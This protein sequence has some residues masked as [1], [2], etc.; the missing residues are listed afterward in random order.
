MKFC[1]IIPHY[2]HERLFELFL[3]KILDLGLP[4]IIVDDGSPQASVA[5]LETL[6]SKYDTFTLI[7]H[8]RNRGKGAAVITACQH[9]SAMGFDNVIQIDADGQHCIDDVEKM[10]TYAQAN[11]NTIISGRPYF[12]ESAPKARVY[13]RKVT[14]FWVAIETLSLRVKDS[15]CGFR[16]YP[17]NEIET[18]FDN[19]HF[20]PRMDFD[21]EIL[22]KAVWANMDLHFIPTKVIYHEDTVS[23]FDYLRD[24]MMLINLHIRLVAGMLK[25]SPV[26]LFRR[27]RGLFGR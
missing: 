10:M 25:R 23:H 20:G 3:P 18:L 14:D 11:P 2:K 15:L 5:T 24:N 21:T 9:A 26:L 13:G 22:V 7:K 17:L 19:Y 8:R 12:D 4:C 16:V 6:I 27:V 1:I